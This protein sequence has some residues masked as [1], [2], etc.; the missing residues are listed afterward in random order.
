MSLESAWM[1]FALA[2]SPSFAI[3]GFY[4]AFAMWSVAWLFLR[5]EGNRTVNLFN[6]M[7]VGLFVGVFGAIV[8]GGSVAALGYPLLFLSPLPI[9]IKKILFGF[10][11]PN[12]GNYLWWRAA[13][14]VVIQILGV[15]IALIWLEAGRDPPPM[16]QPPC[17][18]LAYQ[19]QAIWSFFVRD[20]EVAT[21][22]EYCSARYW[23]K[24]LDILLRLAENGN[25]AAMNNLG[26]MYEAGFGVGRSDELAEKYYRRAAERGNR[27]AQ[28]N[29]GALLAGD[30][31]ANEKREQGS[32]INE[33]K[34]RLAEGYVWALIAKAQHYPNVNL[35]TFKKRLTHVELAEAERL[36]RLWLERHSVHKQS[37][38]RFLAK[39]VP[40][41]LRREL[42]GAA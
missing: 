5:S 37:K 16:V 7:K 34:H 3:G 8:V 23:T 25:V 39:E 21:A 15:V 18:P 31:L 27:T 42:W 38:L 11:S 19:E 2:T 9:E 36:A 12:E 35:R 17:S 10:L 32:E 40:R 24:A 13:I 33:I 6:A 41:V 20:E 28:F 1:E 22:I 4:G 29:L 30:I 14:G 26:V